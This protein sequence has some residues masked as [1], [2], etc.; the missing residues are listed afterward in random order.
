MSLFLKKKMYFSVLFFS[1]LGWTLSAWSESPSTLPIRLG[2]KKNA[3]GATIKVDGRALAD[4]LTENGYELQGLPKGNHKFEFNKPGFLPYSVT[5]EIKAGHNDP[6]VVDLQSGVF[7]QAGK[8]IEVD[9]NESL[10][11]HQKEMKQVPH[12]TL[13]VTVPEGPK[14]F[15]VIMDS[16]PAITAKAGI[17][18]HVPTGPHRFQ[19]LSDACP[20]ITFDRT[21]SRNTNYFQQFSCNASESPNYATLRIN[22]PKVENA[23]YAINGQLPTK[24]DALF[25]V[26]GLRVLAGD[27]K[28]TVV[29]PDGRGNTVDLFLQPKEVRTV[30]L[31]ISETGGLAINSTPSGAQV[32]LGENAEPIGVTPIAIPEV[33]AGTR[34]LQLTLPRHTPFDTTVALT[35]G[36]LLTLN[37]SL[38]RIRAAST[39]ENLVDQVNSQSVFSAL[40]NDPGRATFYAGAGYSNFV[41]LGVMVGAASVGRFKLDIAAEAATTGYVYTGAL[42]ARMTLGG[43]GPVRFALTNAFVGG[44]GIRGRNTFGY[45]GALP[46]T[47]KAGPVQLTGAFVMQVNTD[48]LCPSA[49]D[50]KDEYMRDPGGFMSNYD[51]ATGAEHAGDRCVGRRSDAVTVNGMSAFVNYPNPIIGAATGMYNSSDPQYQTQASPGRGVGVLE[52]FLSARFLLRA[53]I[54][55]TLVGSKILPNGKTTPAVGLTAMIEGAPGQPERPAF[56][57]EFNKLFPMTDFPFYGYLGITVK[58]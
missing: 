51:A 14:S 58:N 45:E 31:K 25:A 43:L 38:R 37:N 21:I 5:R 12:G 3:G 56:R 22:S 20:A 52:R 35:P 16:Y 44:G 17:G 11:E 1:I 24:P 48:R 15:Q 53:A 13:Y 54:E 18:I 28:L 2:E 27:I 40:A 41:R 39:S 34:S 33:P 8:K 32:S 46:V 29:M 6:L 26:G 23:T 30:E 19:I 57:D 50:L 49:D 7:T 9:G 55:V 10:L 47:L 36:T 4:S 42:R